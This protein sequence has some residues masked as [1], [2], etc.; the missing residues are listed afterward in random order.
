MQVENSFAKQTTNKFQQRAKLLSKSFT[1]DNLELLGIACSKDAT[2]V[3]SLNLDCEAWPILTL[4]IH[5]GSVYHF[6]VHSPNVDTIPG[7]N[8]KTG[9]RNQRPGYRLLVSTLRVVQQL[10]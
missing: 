7:H 5:L 3:C 8:E 9:G 4:F 2:G 6:L 1:K 10:L